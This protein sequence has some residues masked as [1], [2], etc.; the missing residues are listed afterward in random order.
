MLVLGCGD[1]EQPSSGPLVR[2][3]GLFRNKTPSSCHPN[4]KSGAS[5]RSPMMPQV[6]QPHQGAVISLSCSK[7]AGFC[8]KSPL[9]FIPPSSQEED[10]LLKLK[11]KSEKQKKSVQ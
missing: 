3:W 4:S 7:Q 10:T 6:C 9:R 8:P 1:N 11:T 2:Q 5:G